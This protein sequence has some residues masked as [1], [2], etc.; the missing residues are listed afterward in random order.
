MVATVIEHEHDHEVKG[1]KRWVFSTNH[2]DIGSMYLIFAIIAGIIGGIMSLIMRT[3]LA[4]PGDGILNGELSDVQCINNRPWINNDFLYDNAS[5][6][7]RFWQLVCSNY[8]W[9]TRYGIS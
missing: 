3:E 6:D 8:D 9:C 4:A 1:W 5:N 7:R 2:K